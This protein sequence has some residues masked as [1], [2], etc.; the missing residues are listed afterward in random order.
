MYNINLL[1]K[2]GE[3]VKRMFLF[4]DHAVGFVLKPG[5]NQICQNKDVEGPTVGLIP[6]GRPCRNTITRGLKWNLNGETMEFGG[7]VSSC[8]IV[9]DEV[10]PH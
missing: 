10:G 2:W 9:V 1:Y 8:N 7:L 4:S 5:K 3:K 6:I